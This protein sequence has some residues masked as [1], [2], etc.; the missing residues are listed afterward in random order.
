MARLLPLVLG[1]WVRLIVVCVACSGSP[2]PWEL[3]GG[4]RNR[5]QLPPN[6]M[7]PAARQAAPATASHRTRGP[8]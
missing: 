4:G 2:A 3:V 8:G 1:S 5:L 6:L 7:W